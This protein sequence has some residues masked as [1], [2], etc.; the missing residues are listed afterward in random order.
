MLIG[1][2]FDEAEASRPCVANGYAGKPCHTMKEAGTGL[3]SEMLQSE[4]G[5]V[6]T[7]RA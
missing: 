5:Y 1:G 2:R 6:T 3:E 4:V 7:W